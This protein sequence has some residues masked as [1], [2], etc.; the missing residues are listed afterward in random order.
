MPPDVTELRTPGER[1]ARRPLRVEK[2]LGVEHYASGQMG[3]RHCDEDDEVFELTFVDRGGHV[4]AILFIRDTKADE[5]VPFP[6]FARVG[7]AGFT[8]QERLPENFA[9]TEGM[10]AQLDAALAA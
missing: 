4:C 10:I 8:T 2:R 9:P 1:L 7:W 3:V 5:W 6:V